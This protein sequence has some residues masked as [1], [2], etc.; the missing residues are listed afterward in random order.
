MTTIIETA[1]HQFCVE[2]LN[3]K[4]DIE[5]NFIV[6]GGRLKK[7]RDE[8]LFQP[9]YGSFVEYLWEMRMSEP[10]ASRLINIYEKFIVEYQISPAKVAE[11]GGWSSLAE[12]L[13]V[14]HS[15]EDAEHWLERALVLTKEDLR[16]EIK[17]KRTGKL[18]ELCDHSDSYTIKVCRLCGER[19]RIYD[20]EV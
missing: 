13:P 14:V 4:H 12:T 8:N 18:M 15:R 3:L 17:E 16:K 19:H 2:T 9:Q 10:T 11:A 5:K 20:E 7:I 1:N 6:I